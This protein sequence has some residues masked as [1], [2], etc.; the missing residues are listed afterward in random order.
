[1]RPFA[2]FWP[3]GLPR[4]QEVQLNWRVLLF[5]LAVS[6]VSGCS[7]VWPRPCARPRAISN[8]RCAPDRERSPAA[9]IGCT[10]PSSRRDCH[11]RR[12][13]GFRGIAGKNHA[14]MSSLD[15]G[16]DIHNVLT[17]RTALSPATLADPERTRVAWKYLLD[18]ARRV[19]GVEAIAMIDTVPM[20]EGS[21]AS[22]TPSP[23]ER[24]RRPRVSHRAGQLRHAGI[25]EVTGIPLRRGRFLTDDDRQ[26]N[27]SVVV[28]DDVMAQQAFPG[29]DPIGKLIWIA[30]GPDPAIVSA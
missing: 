11:R 9:P 16:V 25:P 14:A 26:G 27:A 13:A 23:R 21:N 8:G 24:G 20:R 1:M 18:Q 10:A 2:L 30:I 22:T 29:Q 4:V 7:S 28:I 12:P 5:A 19:P 17:A 15:P 3:G 6:L